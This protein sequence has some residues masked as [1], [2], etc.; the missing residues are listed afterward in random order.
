[1][2]TTPSNRHLSFENP[3]NPKPATKEEA[4][5]SS[6]SRQIKPEATI[7]SP[8]SSSK[9]IYWR[10]FAGK[11]TNLPRPISEES[12]VNRR[13]FEENPV[14][15]DALEVTEVNKDILNHAEV[16]QESKTAEKNVTK[17][18]NRS[19][20]SSKTHRLMQGF[21]VRYPSHPRSY[22]DTT[23]AQEVFEDTLETRGTRQFIKKGR[24]SKSDQK[25][26]CNFFRKR[27]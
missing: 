14:T 15:T 25:K 11:I 10:K 17:F 8:K 2:T 26:I 5:K 18:G 9:T 6:E 19:K 3:I 21:D 13:K 20:I 12:S 22:Q 16:V 4:G 7:Y 24:L 27:K 23:D 1:M